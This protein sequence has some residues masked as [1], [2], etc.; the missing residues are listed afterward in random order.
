MENLNLEH[1]YSWLAGSRHTT[2]VCELGLAV[3]RS[4]TKQGRIR[5]TDDTTSECWI[6]CKCCRPNT[7]AQLTATTTKDDT[8]TKRSFFPAALIKA[9]G[10]GAPL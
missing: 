9:L 2:A 1:S 3:V 4:I 8:T 7:M 5:L 10:C 6:V